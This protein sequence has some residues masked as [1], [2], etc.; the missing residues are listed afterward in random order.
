[1]RG[2]EGFSGDRAFPDRPRW[3]P[4]AP[5]GP[6]AVLGGLPRPW[7]SREGRRPCP[8]HERV[9]RPL[10]GRCAVPRASPAIER[11]LTRWRASCGPE[12]AREAPEAICPAS[13]CSGLPSA[14]WGLLL[15]SRGLRPRSS[16]RGGQVEPAGRPCGLSVFCADQEPRPPPPASPEGLGAWRPEPTPECPVLS[17]RSRKSVQDGAGDR[18]PRVEGRL[19][20]IGHCDPRVAIAGQERSSHLR[21]RSKTKTYSNIRISPS[22]CRGRGALRALDRRRFKGKRT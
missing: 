4:A 22:P 19:V 7:A 14:A 18:H 15:P 21:S 10:G 12:A 2:P 13:S 16:A 8:P 6:P 3:S 5:D 11:S 1:M 9:S 20:G 17:R